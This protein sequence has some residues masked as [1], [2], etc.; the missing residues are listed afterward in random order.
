MLNPGGGGDRGLAGQRNGAVDTHTC[1]LRTLTFYLR[2]EVREASVTP[3]P[4]ERG[5]PAEL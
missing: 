1:A 4:G 2:V 3:D 5:R